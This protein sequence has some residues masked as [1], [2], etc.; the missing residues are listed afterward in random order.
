MNK[1]ALYNKLSDGLWHSGQD[2]AD[3]FEV[4]RTV[5]WKQIDKLR[6]S[7]V[8]VES[9]K[10]K[11]YRLQVS[12]PVL[13][14]KDRVQSMLASELNRKAILVE[15]YET[16][17]S[18]ND[19]CMERVSDR[20]EGNDEASF[21]ILAD[22]QTL[23]RGRRGKSWISPYGSSV[24]MSLSQ[25]FEAGAASLSG[26]SLVVGIAVAQAIEKIS[27]STAVGLKWP[28]DIYVNQKKLG[29]ILLEVKGDLSGP[30]YAIIG[31]G[32]NVVVPKAEVS[33]IDQ[34]YTTLA[35]AYPKV[36]WDKNQLVAEIVLTLRELLNEFV[37]SGFDVFQS[38][39]Q[40]RDIFLGRQ[41]V[42]TISDQVQVQGEYHGV[43]AKGMLSLQTE[44]G[45][46][47]YA[48]G[49]VSLRGLH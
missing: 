1:S 31:I 8:A 29:G 14:S 4:S 28:N 49:E 11:G 19:I 16:V 39:W 20:T 12:A 13:F 23:G 30:C 32:V 47:T 26:L 27:G 21:L 22:H 35:E 34:P 40:K 46:K 38:R 48:G 36:D 6:A 42:L 7:G 41:V 3:H 45:I 18:T 17:T 44:Q 15:T 2:L 43:D 9:G 5:I 37:E 24:Y 10:G 33:K 25:R